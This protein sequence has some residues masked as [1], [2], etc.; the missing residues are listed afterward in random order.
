MARWKGTGTGFAAG[1]VLAVA[2]MALALLFW[3]PQT[4]APDFAAP[5][6]PASV[7]TLGEVTPRP[8]S[9]AQPQPP[10]FDVVR[11]EKDGSSLIA[12]QAAPNSG[13]SVLVDN[14]VMAS[15]MADDAGGFAALFAL[16]PSTQPRLLTLRMRLADGMELVSEESVILAPSDV[17]LATAAV[18][19]VALPDVRPADALPSSGPDT[20]SALAAVT[21]TPAQ[22]EPAPPVPTKT[23]P[24]AL[25]LGPNGVRVL[26]SGDAPQ[27]SAAPRAVVIDAIS[28]SATGA[29]LLGG[30]G[31]PGAVVR[32]YLGGRY[33]AEFMIGEDGAWGGILPEIAAGLHS[34]RADQIDAAANVTARFETPFQRE[35]PTT[36]ADFSPAPPDVRPD[37]PNPTTLPNINATIQM[38]E[39][40]PVPAAIAAPSV[41]VTVTV[42][43]GLTLWAIARDQL[44]GGVLYVQVYEAN[45]D[46]IRDPDLI[47]PGQVFT[48]PQA[49]P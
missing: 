14:A 35:A 32:V 47:Y 46:R 8:P 2:L 1:A 12:G 41:P 18:P 19:P 39:P 5:A 36:L 29:V 15:V 10:R 33:L 42:Q 7:L 17:A 3:P 25:L 13:V 31:M 30:R 43:P 4:P 6:V 16:E 24:T 49:P 38:P 20:I 26:Q 34:L 37:A 28:Y 27:T 9:V 40:P 23:E 11:V 44:G 22:P 45:K 48:L 21:L